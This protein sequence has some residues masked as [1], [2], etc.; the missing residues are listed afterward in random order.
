[1]IAGCGPGAP[2]AQLPKGAIQLD[3]GAVASGAAIPSGF[4]G[5]STEYSS[6]PAYAG[7]DPAAVNPT[8]IQLLRNLDPAGSPVIRIG[9]DTTDWAW[10]PTAG[11]ARP[12]WAR[13][14]LTWR[15]VA[16]ARAVARAARG[17]LILGINFE[18][19]SRELAGGEARALLD[20]V[21]RRQILAFELGNEPEIYGEIGWYGTVL[22][23]P[24][25]YDFHAYLA[26]YRRIS[27]AL[28]ASVPLAGPALAL[29]WPLTVAGRFLSANPRVRVFTFHF[30]PLKRCYNPR[31]SPTYPTLAH[32]LAPRAG[33][34]PAGVGAAV[35]AAAHERGVG[36]RVDEFNSVSCK[37]L[38]GL[39]DTFAS[40]LWVLDALFHLARAGVDGVN[41]HT[42]PGVSYEPFAFSRSRGTWEASVKPIY[43]GL[44]LFAQA[45][46][47]GSRL[48]PT[49]HPSEK[50]LRAW[51]T[52]GRGGAV[53]VV[54]INDSASRGLTLA[55][56]SPRR[57]RSATLERLSAPGLL[58][59][60]GVTLGGQSFGSVTR[61]AM[62]SGSRRLTPLEP[63]QDRYV[64]ELP[65]ASA[66]LLT[67]R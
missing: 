1:M 47:A 61:T 43:Y 62:L 24:P 8:F 67:L 14:V 57:A 49:S 42:L 2:P 26:D 36:V 21:G 11:A 51:A 54:L 50:F 39:S 12:P 52:R 48:L 28:P 63:V 38:P 20:G 53:R 60:S 17:R 32:L 59:R 27:S 58:A 33:R 29:T 34:P 15:W 45:A 9:G 13:F 6:L 18:A 41:V 55:V 44:L 23:R 64:V 25:S 35:A 40:A 31:R 19:D 37:G 4:V 7:G 22:G 56:R 30:Y 66:A 10:W 46:P 65:P 16:I 3:V 5:I